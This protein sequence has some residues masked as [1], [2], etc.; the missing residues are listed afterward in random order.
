VPPIVLPC[1]HHH[2]HQLQQRPLLPRQTTCLDQ[3][4]GPGDSARPP[5]QQS[6]VVEQVRFFC[7]LL[8]NLSTPATLLD[9]LQ[10]CC[11]PALITIQQ[12]QH[13]GP[14]AQYFVYE[15]K[16]RPNAYTTL[17]YLMCS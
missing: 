14:Y 7:G 2:R 15:Q 12:S 1:R 8:S 13:N 6:M 11:P 17:L 10:W 9:T 16:F 3:S 4:T 5:L